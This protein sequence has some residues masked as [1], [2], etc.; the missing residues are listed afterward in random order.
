MIINEDTNTYL[1]SGST[2]NQKTSSVRQYFI[3]THKF[4]SSLVWFLSSYHLYKNILPSPFAYKEQ[5]WYQRKKIMKWKTA[6]LHLKNIYIPNVEPGAQV[7]STLLQCGLQ[8]WNGGVICHSIRA[9]VRHT[10]PYSWQEPY[11]GSDT[12]DG[13]QDVI[14]TNA[15]TLVIVR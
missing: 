15:I 11:W 1:C 8:S 3:T 9:G 13:E 10:R 2:I 6:V 7:V 5:S 12:T 14:F 4:T